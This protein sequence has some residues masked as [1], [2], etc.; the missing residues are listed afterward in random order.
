MTSKD[1][2]FG[3]RLA[4]KG[5]DRAKVA[6]EQWPAFEERLRRLGYS[7]RSI[8]HA[9]RTLSGPGTVDEAL[10]ALKDGSKPERDPMALSFKVTE[11]YESSMAACAVTITSVERDDFGIRVT[12]DTFPAPVLGSGLPRSGARDDLGNEY[13][14]RGGGSIGLLQP[15]TESAA[16]PDSAEALVRGM[17][18]MPLPL[19]TATALYIRITW[20][21]SDSSIWESPAHEVCVSLAG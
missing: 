5:A 11:T 4:A 21:T 20:H 1:D 2:Q 17:L 15:R 10:Q 18:T 7:P 14:N 19:S 9:F 16:M 3:L 13:E 6:S 12:Y 8:A